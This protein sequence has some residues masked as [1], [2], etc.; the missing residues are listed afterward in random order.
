MD[1]IAEVAIGVVQMFIMTTNVILPELETEV[2]L[3]VIQYLPRRGYRGESLR[4][5]LRYDTIRCDIIL[6]GFRVT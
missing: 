3:T 2:Q 1:N 6:D 4:L 5:L